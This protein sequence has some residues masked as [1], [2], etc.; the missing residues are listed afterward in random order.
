MAHH[1][2]TDTLQPAARTIADVLLRFGTSSVNEAPGPLMSAQD[3][4]SAQVLASRLEASIRDSGLFYESH[5][6]RWF[7]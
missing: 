5:L 3:A 1:L 6:K 2:N 4:P 7:R